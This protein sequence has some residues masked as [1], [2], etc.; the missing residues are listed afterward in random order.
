MYRPGQDSPGA[1]LNGRPFFLFF[2][3]RVGRMEKS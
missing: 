1:G 3:E 2:G